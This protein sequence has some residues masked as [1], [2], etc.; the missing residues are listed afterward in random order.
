MLKSHFHSKEG[1]QGCSQVSVQRQV[2]LLD[3]SHKQFA[4]IF[5]LLRQDIIEWKNIQEK[6]KKMLSGKGE[7]P[8]SNQEGLFWLEKASE[9]DCDQG[10]QNKEWHDTD[11]D[12]LLLVSS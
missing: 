12:Q 6:A 9:A 2:S 11:T 8:G 10:L 4:H 7:S 1:N 3:R 5:P